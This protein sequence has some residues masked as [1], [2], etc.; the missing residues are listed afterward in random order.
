MGIRYWEK[1]KKV[2]TVLSSHN[3]SKSRRT[4]RSRGKPAK[5]NNK[6]VKTTKAKKSDDGIQCVQFCRW[7]CEGGTK[8]CV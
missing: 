1:K 3:K 7:L 8:V 5:L 2:A 6:L 4:K